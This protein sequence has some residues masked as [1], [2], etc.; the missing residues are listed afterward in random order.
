MDHRQSFA[1]AFGAGD[2]AATERHARMLAAKVLIFQGLREARAR[3]SGGQAGVLVD[4]EL[5]AQVLRQARQEGLTLAMPVEQSGQKLLTL[6]YGHETA[7]HIQ[8]FDPN[9]VKVLV[10]MNPDD[11]P[12]DMSAQLAVLRELSAM[13]Q[14]DRRALLYELL[15]PPTD[16]Q[17]RRTA[18]RDAYDR[19]MR[20]AL[21]AQVIATNHQAGV[22]PALW[23]IE[24]LETP[25][26]AR[27]V[28]A[29]VKAG[30]RDADCIVLGRDAPQ[31]VL[32]H[33]L[34]VAAGVPGF[35]G[36]AVGRSIWEVPLA[37]YLRDDDERRLVE[38]VCANYLH[39]ADVYLDAR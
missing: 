36:F 17:L 4:E 1:A 12:S 37:D 28:V 16:D 21:A 25:D 19:D 27:H 24:G 15:V 34:S 33:W 3:V 22:E 7:M 2:E 35:V 38:A 13:L 8:R 30:G 29:A 20:P 26:A 23:K 9:Y 11:N 18:G 5:G 32:D 39:C 6:Q 31:P 10:R 14:R